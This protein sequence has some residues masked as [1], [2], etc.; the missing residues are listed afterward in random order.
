MTLKAFDKSHI[1]DIVYFLGLEL[2]A[3]AH[4]F[5]KMDNRMDG[6][7]LARKPYLFGI[8]KGHYLMKHNFIN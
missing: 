7:C 3:S 1:M 2:L 8:E 5:Q 6:S 4:S